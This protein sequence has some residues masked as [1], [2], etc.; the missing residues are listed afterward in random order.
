M[1]ENTVSSQI[2]QSELYGGITVEEHQVY[3]F[4][5]GIV[6][7][8]HLTQFALL[9]YEDT[10]I[11][12]LRSFS[13]EISLMLF[14]AIH[15]DNNIS[16]HIDEATVKELG[17]NAQDDLAIFY[18]LRFIDNKPYI[19]LRAPILV[20][21]TTQR[22]CQYVVPDDSLNMREPLVVKGDSSC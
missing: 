10:E 21:P 19:N 11:F 4:A 3:Q 5:Q 12:E 6:G 16:F 13:E 7:F 2:L 14:P 20:V 22:G 18:I 9:P 17:V 8:S 1:S 15:S